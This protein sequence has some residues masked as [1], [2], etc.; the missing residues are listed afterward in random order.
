MPKVERDPQLVD[1]VKF[2]VEKH[3]CNVAAAARSCG[4][5]RSVLWRVCQTGRAISR[6]RGRLLDAIEQQKNASITPPAATAATTSLQGSRIPAE[7]LA[8]LRG[9]LTTMLLVVDAYVQDSKG[10]GSCIREGGNS[11]S[12]QPTFRANTISQE[13]G[14]TY[15]SIEHPRRP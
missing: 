13:K 2:L 11:T 7:E 15:G 3:G 10:E 8:H 4:I 14:A 5:D 1:A 9:F 6:T 12:L